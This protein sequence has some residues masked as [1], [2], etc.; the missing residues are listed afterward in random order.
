MVNESLNMGCGPLGALDRVV[1]V[2]TREPHGP[3]FML[4]TGYVAVLPLVPAECVVRQACAIADKHCGRNPW[5][6]HAAS[7]WGV[8]ERWCSGDKDEAANRWGL[9]EENHVGMV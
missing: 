8:S 7:T 2:Q 4:S 5:G 1:A 3:G 9:W 6:A